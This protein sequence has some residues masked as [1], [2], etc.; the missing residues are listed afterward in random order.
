M[1]CS[2]DDTNTNT[3]KKDGS[4][5]DQKVVT[6]DQ[7]KIEPI[8]CSTNTCHDFVANKLLLPTD[9]TESQKYALQ[10]NGKPYNSLGGI[11]ALIASQAS[12]L[13]IQEEMD[14]A[15]CE[16]AALILMRAQAK[17][18]TAGK[19]T[20]QTWVAKKKACCTTTSD[21]KTCCTE[22]ATACFN[23]TTEFEKDSSGTD[24]IFGGNIFG[25]KIA[26]GSAKMKLNLT[27]SGGAALALNLKYVQIKGDITATGITNGVLSGAIPKDDLDNVI[28]PQIATMVNT[29]YTDPKGD[30][31]TKDLL[32]TLFDTDKD[33]KITAAEVKNN[34]LIKTFLDGDVD[35][36]GDGKKEL[37]LGL[38]FT[39]VKAKIK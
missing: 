9:S 10:F 23:G 21:N 3:T 12:G 22:A 11:L 37:S 19:T 7:G 6:P 5:A 29:A 32:K 33:G 8:N 31:K 36:D 24:Y 13:N 25:G 34:G 16:G 30:Q 1:A 20:L 2:D 38:G 4:V 15:L 28:V 18:L 27:L 14:G 35:V 17:S 39:T 26:A